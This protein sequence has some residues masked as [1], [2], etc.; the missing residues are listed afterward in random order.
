MSGTRTS[1]SGTNQPTISWTR[2]HLL[3][4]VFL[5]FVPGPLSRDLQPLVVLVTAGFG[6][7]SGYVVAVISA[8]TGRIISLLPSCGLCT[9][10]LLQFVQKWSISSNQPHIHGRQAAQTQIRHKTAPQMLNQKVSNTLSP[11]LGSAL[12]LPLRSPACSLGS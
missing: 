11:P 9:T 12:T 8:G 7:A 5:E 10:F 1:A 4:M 6:C 2:F 3:L